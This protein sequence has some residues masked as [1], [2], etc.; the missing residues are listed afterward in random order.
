MNYNYIKSLRINFSGRLEVPSIVSVQSP[1]MRII[2]GTAAAETF[3]SRVLGIIREYLTSL[4]LPNAD[5][6]ETEVMLMKDSEHA[7]YFFRCFPGQRGCRYGILNATS[8]SLELDI[9][10]E[11]SQQIS[12]A[13]AFIG[14]ADELFKDS[15]N[16]SAWVCPEKLVFKPEDS[17]EDEY[18]AQCREAYKYRVLAGKYGH[19]KG[20]A[21]RNGYGDVPTFEEYM[22]EHWND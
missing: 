12:E 16:F 13:L 6:V 22:A 4:G 9:K 3:I 8:P 1:D 11:V 14:Y 15:Y 17:E 5:S 10:D 21:L 2:E 19:L 18:L 7:L 20:Q